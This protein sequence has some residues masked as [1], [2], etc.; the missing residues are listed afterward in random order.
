MIFAPQDLSILSCSLGRVCLDVTGTIRGSNRL[1]RHFPANNRSLANRIPMIIPQST[2]FAN[3]SMT[4]NDKGNRICADR[5]ANRAGC[6]R[7]AYCGGKPSVS[8]ERA[9]RDK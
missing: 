8:S 2:G 7:L 9:G 6:L 4:G 1:M 3:Y 5:A